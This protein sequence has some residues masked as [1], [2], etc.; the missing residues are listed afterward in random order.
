[1]DKTAKTM[2]RWAVREAMVWR[3]GLA[4]DAATELVGYDFLANHTRQIDTQKQL[5]KVASACEKAAVA[6]EESMQEESFV[7][8]DDER[9]SWEEV[10]KEV[11]KIV[12]RE[13]K[14]LVGESGLLDDRVATKEVKREVKALVG[15]F[16]EEAARLA[17]RRGTGYVLGHA[18]AGREGVLGSESV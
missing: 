9:Y 8:D 14:A 10:E 17:G 12:K 3:A 11:R 6:W 13:V 5:E 7:Q 4:T 2:N 15:E 1:M 18:P 16:M